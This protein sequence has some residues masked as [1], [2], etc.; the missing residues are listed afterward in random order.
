[1]AAIIHWLVPK[2]KRFFEMLAEQSQNVL[3]GA[4]ELKH[5]VYNYSEFERNERK[6]KYQVIKDLEHK[7]DEIAHSII[8]KLDKNFRTSI[9]KGYIKQLTVLLDDILNLIDAVA[10]RFVIFGIERVNDYILKL[11]DLIADVVDELNKTILGLRDLKDIKSKFQRVYELEKE[12]DKIYGDA[13]SD[14]F[15]YYKNPVDIIK[16]KEIYE[17]LEGIADKC[18]D[19]MKLVKSVAIKQL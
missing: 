13:L 5:F 8:D 19:V 15:H 10:S 9:N 12:A 4:K 6:Y 3:N 16:Y 17:L 7:G 14:L 18:K 11:T 1:M 2:E